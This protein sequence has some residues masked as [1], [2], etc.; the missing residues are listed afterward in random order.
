MTGPPSAR[1]SH[2]FCDGPGRELLDEE[3]VVKRSRHG[4]RADI[5]RN[6]SFRSWGQIFAT[7][8]DNEVESARSAI[9]GL[10]FSGDENGLAVVGDNTKHGTEF[11]RRHLLAVRIQI[12][13]VLLHFRLRGRKCQSG[14]EDNQGNERSKVLFHGLFPFASD[15]AEG[16]TSFIAANCIRLRKCKRTVKQLAEDKLNDRQARR[17]AI[18]RSGSLRPAKIGL[19]SAKISESVKAK[20]VAIRPHHIWCRDE[21]VA[22]TSESERAQSHLLLYSPKAVYWCDYWFFRLH[23][24]MP[25]SRSQQ[26][27]TPSAAP[28]AVNIKSGC[29]VRWK[30]KTMSETIEIVVNRHH[31]QVCLATHA[32]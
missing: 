14:A 26:R 2:A 1:S 3:N 21:Y 29:P 8:D 11:W 18:A 12:E 24:L 10:G 25:V 7:F 16:F 4:H 32:P 19:G 23:S 31:V 22:S 15:I 20:S 28:K 5:R 30:P 9:A 27:Q 13:H 6:G 17:Q